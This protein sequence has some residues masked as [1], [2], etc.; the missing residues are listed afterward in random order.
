LLRQTAEKF[1]ILE[2]TP[3]GL[4]MLKA[5]QPVTLTKPVVTAKPQDRRVGD[6]ACDEPLF[7]RLRELRKRLADQINVPAYIVFSDVAL[8]Q[9]ARLYPA[10][11]GEFARISGVGERKLREFGAAFLGEIAQHLQA[12]PRQMF[13]DDS[14]VTPPPAPAR[15]SLGD[16]A[17]ETV[18]QFRSGGSVAE[19]ARRRG[20]TPGTIYSHLAEAIERGEPVEA[21]KFFTPAELSN[22]AGAFNRH[23]PGALTPVFEA[24]GGAVDYDRLRLFRAMQNG[25]PAGGGG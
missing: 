15:S 19:I 4:A 3:A 24:L 9:M 21:G 14:F 22:I 16:S 11:P 18:R 8:R 17:R 1:S 2:V 5:R 12:N 10:T 25:K 13:A 7:E 20:V 6:I 23:G